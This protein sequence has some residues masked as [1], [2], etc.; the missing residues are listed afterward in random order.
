MLSREQLDE[1]ARRVRLL[2]CDVDGVL[3]DGRVYVDDDGRETRAFSALDGVG[4]HLLDDAGIVVAW[5]T[6]SSSPSVAHRAR[7]LGVRH[8]IQDTSDKL[9]AWERLTR[10]LKFEP[11]QCAHIGDDLPDVPLLSACGLSASVPHAPLSVRTLVHY[12]TSRDGGFGAVR[13][14][15]E[16]ILTAQDRLK[17]TVRKRAPTFIPQS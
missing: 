2:S 8:V 14:F 17:D 16:L 9:A 12:V 4:I 13:E 6:G 1:R 7:M 10:E 5:I 3:T 15:A 11:S